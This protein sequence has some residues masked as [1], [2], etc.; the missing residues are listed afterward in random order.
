[1]QMIQNESDFFLKLPAFYKELYLCGR[2][3]CWWNLYKW[4]SF[5]IQG[6]VCLSNLLISIIMVLVRFL[7]VSVERR[8]GRLSTQANL[9]WK[10][11]EIF[12]RKRRFVLTGCERNSVWT[13]QVCRSKRWNRH[14][15]VQG[16][17][18]RVKTLSDCYLIN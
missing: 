14:V 15:L 3:T 12:I 13:P 16:N 7:D 6:R 4:T 10:C 11:R 8:I 17:S 5:D 18:M 1:M 2:N 9:A